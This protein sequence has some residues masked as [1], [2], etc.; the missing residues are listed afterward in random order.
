MKNLTE[1][2][3]IAMSRKHFNKHL[4]KRQSIK[5]ATLL[6]GIDTGCNFNAIVLMNKEGEILGRF[7][8][9]QYKERIQ[10]F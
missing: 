4:A 2:E 9:I 3:V 5:E 6:V 7:P 10:L 1:K 8:T